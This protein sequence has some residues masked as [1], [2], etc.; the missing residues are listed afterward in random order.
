MAVHAAVD[1]VDSPR[2][3]SVDRRIHIAKG[4]FV[5]GEL[6]VGVH[7]PFA[8]QEHEL[9]FGEFG[10]DEREAD[11]VEGGIPGGKPGELPFV[12]HRHNFATFYMTPGAVAAVAAFDRRRRLKFV[13]ADPAGN[14]VVIELL[15]PDEA[16]PSLALHVAGIGIVQMVLNGA[17]ELVGVAAAL[18]DGGFE[19]FERRAKRLFGKA[20]ADG[21][22]AAGRNRKREMGAGLGAGVFRIDGGLI[23]L[24]HIFVEGVFEVAGGIV[25]AEQAA[26]VGVVVAEEQFGGA[27]VGGG[28]DVP[29]VAAELI[30]VGENRA[31]ID[32]R[33]AGLIEFGSPR[34]NVAKPELRHNVQASFFRAAIDDGDL[35]QH[36]VRVGFGVFDENV[37][38]AVVVEDAGID[39][40]VFGFQFA[41]AAIFV[42]E[43]IVGKCALRILVEHL[44]IRVRRQCVEIP[45]ALFHVFAVIAFAVGKAV[46]AFF[47]NGV[48]FVPERE[49]QIELAV[50]VAQAGQAVVA[51]AVS[52]AASMVVREVI[53]GGAVAAVIFADRAPLAFA[54]VCT[55]LPPRELTAI[56]FVEAALFGIHW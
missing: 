46:E 1:L 45:V 10:I 4:P 17:V 15:V 56:G 16:R 20:G 44:Q 31:G 28:I 55:P 12:G 25:H 52:A 7:E 53:P 14:V 51:P 21:A 18:G 6:A 8:A 47:Q 22:R 49:R 35:H 43:L 42:Q 40:F 2:S 19:I 9:L 26:H 5:R 36:V 37:E 11:A 3:P 39:Q 41:P 30:M 13:A 32:L 54:G 27:F 34:P 38:V 50:V 23:I 48:M 24:N 29:M 33:Q